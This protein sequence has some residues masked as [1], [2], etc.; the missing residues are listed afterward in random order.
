MSTYIQ[1]SINTATLINASEKR[2]QTRT[3]QTL[4]S[5][6]K[7]RNRFEL[8]ELIQIFLVRPSSTSGCD[9]R[10]RSPG[11]SHCLQTG[12]SRLGRGSC[13]A[14]TG[15][16]CSQVQWGPKDVKM[17]IQNRGLGRGNCDAG[18]GEVKLRDWQD[19]R[20]SAD[21]IF[22]TWNIFVVVWIHRTI[23]RQTKW[24]FP[25]PDPGLQ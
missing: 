24:E 13:D 7:V 22:D 19:C 25:L 15:E 21:K 2:R 16:Y 11:S 1:S 14:W 18:T 17:G 10:W 4:P 8:F 20:S 23:H 3:A 5:E 6:A 9:M 12:R